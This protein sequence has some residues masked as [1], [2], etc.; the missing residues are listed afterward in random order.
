MLQKCQECLQV[1][2]FCVCNVVSPVM[3]DTRVLV[4]MHYREFD[5]SSNTGRLVKYGLKNSEIRV[6]G[7]NDNRLETGDLINNGYRKLFLFPRADAKVITPNMIKNETEPVMLI[8]PD[9]NWRQAA[10]MYTRIG[11]KNNF[12]CVKLPPGLPAEYQLRSNAFPE[13]LNT[14]EAIIRAMGMI[15]GKEVEDRLNILYKTMTTRF[16]YTRGRAK[17]SDVYGGIPEDDISLKK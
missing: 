5:K 16:L 9:G 2:K 10:R 12:E 3:T 14:F 8:I 11:R 4:I 15:E 17:K 7:F 13:R 1:L 6:H